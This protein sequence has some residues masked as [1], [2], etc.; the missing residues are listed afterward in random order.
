MVRVC[1]CL[2]KSQTAALFQM[3]HMLQNQ[4]AVFVETETISKW[5]SYSQAAY[6]N[7]KISCNRTKLWI[8]L[9]R[10]LKARMLIRT[11]VANAKAR[12]YFCKSNKQIRV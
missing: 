4:T 2:V 11:I 1:W 8:C 3:L 9:S 5:I 10:I 12:R 7:T 6:A